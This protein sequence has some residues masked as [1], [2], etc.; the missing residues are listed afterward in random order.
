M[1][2]DLFSKS[3]RVTYVAIF[4]REWHSLTENVSLTSMRRDGIDGHWYD[5]ILAPNAHWI[6]T[7]IFFFKC[8]E[9]GVRSFIIIFVPILKSSW[10]YLRYINYNS[11]IFCFSYMVKRYKFSVWQN[12]EKND[13]LTR[14]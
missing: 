9:L 14:D 3:G 6:G 4:D 13:G 1:T 11:I 8:A 7:M 10:F 2:R 12:K 5:V